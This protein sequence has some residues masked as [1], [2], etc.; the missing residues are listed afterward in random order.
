[1]R[2][3]LIPIALATAGMAVTV[4]VLAASPAGAQI[5]GGCRVTVNRRDAGTA[6]NASTAIKAGE[7]DTVKVVGTAP[8]PI[9]GYDIK[10]KFGPIKFTAKSGTVTGEDNTWT[11]RVKVSDYARYGVGLYRVE[12]A[13]TGTVCTGW[14]YLKITGPFPLTTV[15]GATGAVLAL[16][17]ATGMVSAARRPKVKKVRAS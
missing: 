6:H 12:G 9:K 8:G 16:G 7:R 14:V 10:M 4:G 3:K 1:M 17:G 11:G 13:S 15:A 5:T 2:T